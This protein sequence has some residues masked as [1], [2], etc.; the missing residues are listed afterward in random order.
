MTVTMAKIV[1]HDERRHELLEAVWRLIERNGITGVTVRSIAAESGWSTGSLAHYFADKEDILTS[2]LRL[3]HEEIDKRWAESADGL[4]PSD[5]LWVFVTDNLPLDDR[6][7][8][9]TLLE[10]A[11]WASAVPDEAIRSIQTEE[12]DGL[13]QRLTGILEAGIADGSFAVEPGT[14]DFVAERLLALIDGLSLHLVLY[15]GRLS[16]ETA[17]EIVADDVERLTGARSPRTRS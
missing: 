4:G 1:R 14:V 15:P 8:R 5:A 6:R 13:K 2:A 9:E 16:G 10:M 7:R 12:A 11:Y 17:V 3:S